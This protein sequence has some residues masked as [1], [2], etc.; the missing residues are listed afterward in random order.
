[1]ATTYPAFEEALRVHAAR[2]NVV[3]FTRMCEQ[4]VESYDLAFDEKLQ[5]DSRVMM[6]SFEKEIH[7][8][9]STPLTDMTFLK[10]MEVHTQLSRLIYNEAFPLAEL[11]QEHLS[12]DQLV[13]EIAAPVVTLIEQTFRNDPL[14]IRCAVVEDFAIAAEPDLPDSLKQTLPLNV[15]TIVAYTTDADRHLMTTVA[16][17]LD[18]WF[19]SRAPGEIDTVLDGNTLYVRHVHGAR[20]APRQRETPVPAMTVFLK[21]KFVFDN[22]VENWIAPTHARDLRAIVKQYRRSL[23]A[24]TDYHAL[25]QKKTILRQMETALAT[26]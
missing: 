9:L 5:D 11:R 17:G 19:R 18:P 24:Y 6:M 15:L 26:Y 1:L 14:R 22:N 2:A 23:T 10:L 21:V 8:F 25:N 12:N 3:V 7:E 20:F 4:L 16:N 13:R